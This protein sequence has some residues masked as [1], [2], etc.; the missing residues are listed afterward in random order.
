MRTRQLK[1]A[2]TKNERIMQYAV[3]PDIS[4]SRAIDFAECGPM[5]LDQN[6]VTSVQMATEQDLN[7]LA[8]PLEARRR[9][10]FW[11]TQI[12]DWQKTGSSDAV[13]HDALSKAKAL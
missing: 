1:S 4:F 10:A 9:F 12:K 3:L 2:H 6:L 5:Q 7:G 13:Y 8:F 11:M